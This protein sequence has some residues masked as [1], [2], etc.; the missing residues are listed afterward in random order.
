MLFIVLFLLGLVLFIF[1]RCVSFSE[2]R[3]CS[4][5]LAVGNIV[6]GFLPDSSSYGEGM[7]LFIGVVLYIHNAVY[8]DFF[9]HGPSSRGPCFFLLFFL[10]PQ[11]FGGGMVS[12]VLGLCLS[13]GIPS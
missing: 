11:L 1:W 5:P 9:P 10:L 4:P 7:S 8:G 12:W 2:W 6:L 3:D 13:C